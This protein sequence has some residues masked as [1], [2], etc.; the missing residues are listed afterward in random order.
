MNN[1]S[2]LIPDGESNFALFVARCLAQIPNLRLH[3]L[4]SDPWAPL[5]FSRYRITYSCNRQIRDK[6]ERYLDSIRQSVKQTGAQILLP[7]DEPTVRFMA[8]RPEAVTELAAVTPLPSLETFDTVSNK[9]RLVNFMQ[10]N[11]LPSPP[12]V[13]YTA[14]E[15]FEQNLQELSFP[16]LAKPTRGCGGEGIQRYDNPAT[17][18][19]FLERVVGQSSLQYIVQSFI[20]GYDVDCSVLCR[21]GEI[22]AYTIQRGFLSR[23]KH[24]AA[25]AGIDF[26][27]DD[28]VFDLVSKLVAA[29][30][31]SG[32]AHLDLRYDNRDKQ[33]KVVDFNARYWVSLIGS[34]IVGVNFPYLA[35]LAGLDISFPCPTYRLGRYVAPSSALKQWGLGLWRQH[36]PAFTFSETGLA[37]IL[38]DPLAEIVKLGL[39]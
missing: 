38:A 37:Y 1:L 5:R 22:L 3:I 4:S 19:H 33:V 30:R 8:A 36:R 24:F 25:A 34:L 32:V 17:L 12:T 23:S 16:V 6:D 15:N 35:C 39:R 29:L 9:W 14:D 21:D 11:G 26:I 2:V 7:V 27:T 31:W 18:R 28:Q 10:A 20:P 13:L